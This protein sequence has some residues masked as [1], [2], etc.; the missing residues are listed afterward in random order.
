MTFT[1]M[2]VHDLRV[3]FFYM[4]LGTLEHIQSKL[5]TEYGEMRAAVGE[6]ARN[7]LDLGE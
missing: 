3:T 7:T 2:S 4:Q 6:V 1:N 5:L